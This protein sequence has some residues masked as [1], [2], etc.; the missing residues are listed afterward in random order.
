[1]KQ[2]KVFFIIMALLCLGTADAM[3]RS[4]KVKA[5]EEIKVDTVSVKDFSYA[6][7]V[8]SS[9]GLKGF[10]A[11]RA[12]IDTTNMTTFLNGFDNGDADPA[13]IAVM[14]AYLTGYDIRKQ[15]ENEIMPSIEKRLSPES[16]GKL[17]DK[18]SFLK[19]FR[20]TIDGGSRMSADSANA[21][22][23][24]N[25]NYYTER[26]MMSKWG[27]WKKENEEWLVA[28][29]KKDSVQKT[30]SGLQ[31]KVIVLGDGEKP[32]ANSRV[33][34]NYEGKL[35]DGTVFDSSYKRN[36]PATFG[37]S[38]VIKGWTEALQLMP[39]GSKYELYIPQEL[40]YG[41]TDMREIKPFSTLVFTVELLSIEK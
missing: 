32:T 9:A 19:G 23:E 27:D 38:Q 37:C 7:G 11:Q 8:S 20:A 33:K 16:A 15:A 21:V 34:V 17:V 18:E 40:A 29:A 24:K 30:A 6:F 41:A 25:M 5:T 22:V 36:S 26:E 14:R 4:K 28:N 35:I 3:S 1:M 39:V 12:G 13:M 31:Y 10:L 2:N